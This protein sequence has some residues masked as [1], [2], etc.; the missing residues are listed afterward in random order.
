MPFRLWRY[1]S[2]G[3]LFRFGVALGG[4]FSLYAVVD[5]IEL[6]S[7]APDTTR[8]LLQWLGCRAPFA[9][10]CI[11]PMALVLGILAS[12]SHHRLS[13]EWNALLAS[14][15]G[16]RRLLWVFLPMAMGT[17][18]LSAFLLGQ[19]GPRG[20]CS[21]A[22]AKPGTS[23]LPCRDDLEQVNEDGHTVARIERS[24]L[25]EPMGFA[26]RSSAPAKL[27]QTWQWR[28]ETGW[29]RNAEELPL[30]SP[31]PRVRTSTSA[32]SLLPFAQMSSAELR[33][34]VRTHGEQKLRALPFE[35]QLAL[36]Q[37]IFFAPLALCLLSLGLGA[38]GT[39]LSQGKA[40]LMSISIICFYWVCVS[41]LWQ[42]AGRGDIPAMV[43]GY[44]LPAGVS[45][46][47]AVGL[48]IRR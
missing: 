31:C 12:L 2:Q 28:S 30:G 41:L 13:G 22:S 3:A 38:M 44:G 10:A 29:R 39:Q 17:T 21:D 45:L 42:A 7:H 4:L 46:A 34:A 9:A 43:L 24:P 14:G 5:A 36:R 20:L 37:A 8:Q 32:L 48:V 16:P 11:A 19:G 33:K 35:A 18:A 40:A 27:S 15:I 47:A 25:G 26:V 1:L 23:W 6:T